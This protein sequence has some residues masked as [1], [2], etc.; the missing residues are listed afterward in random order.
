MLTLKIVMVLAIRMY[1]YISTRGVLT[2]H[3][4]VR[5]ALSTSQNS[6]SD[7]SYYQQMVQAMSTGATTTGPP[8]PGK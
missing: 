2:E 1:E 7:T 3:S 8:R 6:A 4:R 5:G